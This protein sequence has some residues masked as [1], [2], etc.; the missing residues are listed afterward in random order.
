MDIISRA[1][2]SGDGE[3]TATK[4]QFGDTVK[5]HFTC[6]LE[7]GKVFDTS[8][9]RA[10]LQFTIGKDNMIAGF[11]QAVTGMSLHESK[12][13][14]IS[15]ENAYGHYRKDLVC[16]VPKEKIPVNF[17]LEVGMQMQ[18][19]QQDG[20][21][22]KLRITGVSDTDVTLDAN[23]PLAGKDLIFD[24]HLIEIIPGNITQSQEYFKK[25]VALQDAGSVDEAMECYKE[26]IKLNP[27]H[28]EA[29]YNLAVI[30]HENG[31]IDK[32]T[33][34]YLSTI[35]LKP[36][37]VQAY[38]N[39]GIALLKEKKADNAI[40]ILQ[41]AIEIHPDY[42]ECHFILG[43]ALRQNN[44]N[45]EAMISYKKA[46]QLKPDFAEAQQELEELM[47]LQR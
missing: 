12:T 23:H 31:L 45:D 17:P 28:A 26:A 2:P 33:Y 5:V 20:Q 7:D 10:P 34:L 47:T 46:L 3:Q 35:G 19:K 8:D 25:G 42:A 9:K 16:V 13:I 40:K 11:D 27:N 44:N 29:C 39:L 1:I 38:I 41:E 18:V 30:F 14:R 22:D 36:E 4:A 15:S 24:V 32:A 37:L 43:N 6:T 21:S